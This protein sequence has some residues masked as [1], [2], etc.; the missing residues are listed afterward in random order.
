M[1]IIISTVQAPFVTGGA[2][3]L[4]NNLKSALSKQGHEAEIVTIPFMDSPVEL[5][6][7]HIVASRLLDLGNS[8]AGKVDLCI[9]LKFP[10]YYIPHP[11]KV[12]WILHQHRAAYD[13][14]NTEYSNIK[15][16]P[17]GNS[18][19]SV[20]YNADNK[21]LKEAKRIY[22]IAE[23]VSK[24]L[25]KYNSISSTPLYHPC[26]D[27]DKFFTSEYGDYIL[28][29]SRVNITKRQMLALEAMLQSKSDIKLYLAG[30]ADNDYEKNRILAFI[31]SNKL[32]NRVKYLD[33]VSQEEKIQLYAN[34]RAVL[35]IPLDEDYG[36]ITLEAMAASKAVITAKDSGGP[37]EFVE[38]NRTG[39]V[40]DATPGSIAAVI[41]ELG[42]SVR[43]SKELGQK[44]KDHLKEMN[45]TWENVVKELT[46][47]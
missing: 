8:W 1:K 25:E 16:N 46:Q 5:I 4:A 23:N 22:T 14:F 6:E 31:K 42:T 10:A 3:F 32:Q 33:Y 39:F 47:P 35:F 37:L 11:N 21:Y 29:P 9:G 26:P 40:V 24:R 30:K 43:L 2:E 36:Y 45:I 19:R 20:V 41:D 18:I 13:L 27:M 15:D 38:N 34:A 44:S 7:N 17:E 28:M 12:N